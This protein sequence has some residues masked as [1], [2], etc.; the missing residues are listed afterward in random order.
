LPQTKSPRYV[1]GRTRR[2][3]DLAPRTRVDALG[4]KESWTHLLAEALPIDDAG[5]DEGR[6]PGSA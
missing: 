2:A 6:P 5:G 3:L 1:I 4:L